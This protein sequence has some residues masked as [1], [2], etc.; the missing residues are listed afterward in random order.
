[1][2]NFWGHKSGQI[3]ILATSVAGLQSVL[4][5][6]NFSPSSVGLQRK[7]R[8]GSFPLFHRHIKVLAC[9]NRE[10]DL[11]G[12]LL[13]SSS[14]SKTVKTP[15]ML[16]RGLIHM[17]GVGVECQ[18]KWSSLSQDSSSLLWIRRAGGVTSMAG[19]MSVISQT[20]VLQNLS[21]LVWKVNLGAV[22]PAFMLLQGV[23]P[24]VGKTFSEW[25]H[26]HQVQRPS[27]S[28]QFQ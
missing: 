13:K 1:M 4:A 15:W 19:Y 18:T 10:S 7:K 25:D 26:R 3:L 17:S 28:W 8:K 14:S 2:A 24:C 6:A 9:C 27:N 5:R 11:Q 21:F 12:K 20:S 16:N 23:V 22:Q